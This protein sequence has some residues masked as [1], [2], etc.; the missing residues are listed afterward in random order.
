MEP[1]LPPRPVLRLYWRF[2]RYLLDD[3]KSGRFSAGAMVLFG[4]I[5]LGHQLWMKLVEPRRYT[6]QP[7]GYTEF[8]EGYLL[9]EGEG[10][11]VQGELLVD[12]VRRD[13]EGAAEP[14]TPAIENSE[15]P[16]L[17]AGET[18]DGLLEAQD[19]IDLRLDDERLSR[20]SPLVRAFVE[21]SYLRQD[22]EVPS[23]FRYRFSARGNR[24]EVVGLR[25]NVHRRYLPFSEELRYQGDILFR[26]DK[27]EVVL[28]A[29]DQT[30]FIL[31]GGGGVRVVDVMARGEAG[32]EAVQELDLRVGG[33]QVATLRQSGG[34]LALRVMRGA[35]ASCEVRLNGSPLP[36]D[37]VRRVEPSDILYLQYD[38]SK[39]KKADFYLVVEE[40]REGV[41]STLRLT[42]Q[43]RT[44]VPEEELVPGLSRALEGVMDTL[45][46]N[47][48][49]K[50]PT[51]AK[52]LQ[53]LNLRLTLA[54]PLQRELQARLVAY[55]RKLDGVGS[56]SK[57]PFRQAGEFR[58]PP[59]R[60]AVTLMDATTGEVL[61]LASYPDQASL[62]ELLASLD[63]KAADVAAKP[64]G[65]RE[66]RAI[67]LR[68]GEIERLRGTL[69]ANQNLPLHQ[70]GSIFKP[71]FGFA[72][73]SVYPALTALEIPSHGENDNRPLLGH[74]MGKFS[75]HSHGTVDGAKFI[76]VSCQ[77]FMEYLGL[78]ALGEPTPEGWK[79]LT[80]GS[81]VRLGESA[82]GGVLQPACEA[83]GKCFLRQ[84]NAA[85]LEKGKPT[86]VRNLEKGKVFQALE[87]RFGVA[88][89]RWNTNTLPDAALYDTALWGD[90]ISQ[91]TEEV[92]EEADVTG[93]FTGVSPVRVVSYVEDFRDLYRDYTQ[94][95][96]GS[97]LNVWSNVAV[98]QAIARLTTGR[99]VSAWM[100]HLEDPTEEADP[101]RPAPRCEGG[102]TPRPPFLRC[103]AK[104]W[105]AAPENAWDI[106]LRGMEQVSEAG[107]AKALKREVE[108]AK[109]ALASA[110]PGEVFR[111]FSKTG[112]V[113]RPWSMRLLV[114][115]RKTKERELVVCPKAGAA[116]PAWLRD[117]ERD[118]LPGANYTFALVGGPPLALPARGVV[119][120]IY[121][122]DAGGSQVAV[123]FAEE[124]KLLELVTEYLRGESQ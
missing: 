25:E 100:G 86:E 54:E 28:R 8:V 9:K 81:E 52:A 61:A 37:S 104:A 96:K 103:P 31:G 53:G 33:A 44:R 56:K 57:E 32:E 23:N 118:S 35:G 15:D 109:K 42:D 17:P 27:P 19:L 65:E 107:T 82:F 105:P 10:A 95:L 119:A 113:R 108:D 115:N 2:W 12:S 102:A 18:N 63:K 123:Q 46:L 90:V 62:D 92:G 16:D 124:A 84:G 6:H 39:T 116:C 13:P 21:N 111:Y 66:Q 99:E 41:I 71:I 76:A 60:A 29:N 78:F 112:S 97:G 55:A 85:T 93:F 58:A 24:L 79:G 14:S 114:T 1:L 122:A 20:A 73:F 4:A 106:V 94:Y 50:N 5:I 80:A 26:Q 98:A 34:A 87:R 49:A 22:L 117:P 120:V 88:L 59:L 67:L 72:V 38:V 3:Q 36:P 121:I 47:V 30:R 74:D 51:G 48:A 45:L 68:R 11:I 91:L 70:I 43:G 77:R 7:V 75:D 83:P 110:Y 64:N 101:G 69:L 40:V 89:T